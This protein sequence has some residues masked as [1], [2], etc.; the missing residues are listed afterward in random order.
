MKG[1][2]GRKE[3]REGGREEKE[4]KRKRA[5]G[6]REREREKKEE[7]EG[8]GKGKGKGKKRKSRCWWPTPVI[9]ATQEAEIRRIIV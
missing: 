2:S 3:G 8:K 5:K 1:E 6:R 4:K 9:L 7:R